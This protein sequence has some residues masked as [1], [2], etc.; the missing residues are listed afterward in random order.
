MSNLD[1][2]LLCIGAKYV[3]NERLH[4]NKAKNEPKWSRQQK[5]ANASAGPGTGRI[6][7]APDLYQLAGAQ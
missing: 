3:L 5:D 7:Q 6:R 1:L 2:N 4:Q